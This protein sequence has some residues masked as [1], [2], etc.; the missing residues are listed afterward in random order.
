[1]GVHNSNSPNRCV[2]GGTIPVTTAAPPNRVPHFA[3]APLLAGKIVSNKTHN[4]RERTRAKLN[5]E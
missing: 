4:R 2:G 1:M 3:R 5:E